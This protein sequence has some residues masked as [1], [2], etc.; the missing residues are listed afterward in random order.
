MG[1]QV[2]ARVECRSEGAAEQHPI[3]VWLAEDRIP[4]VEILEDSVNGPAQAGSPT[5]R[6]LRVRLADGQVLQLD[7]ELPRGEWRV[8]REG[9]RG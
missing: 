9:M 4:V 6:R 3:A 1:V 7:R 5:V 2:I 8:Y